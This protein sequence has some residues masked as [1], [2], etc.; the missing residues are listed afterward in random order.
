MNA[1][2]LTRENNTPSI[3]FTINTMYMLLRTILLKLNSYSIGGAK[4]QRLWI[5]V[6]TNHV[7]RERKSQELRKK[8]KDLLFELFLQENILNDENNFT[9]RQTVKTQEISQGVGGEHNRF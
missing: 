6:A 8:I 3:F 4:F 1:L 2:F 9:P 5:K 7:C